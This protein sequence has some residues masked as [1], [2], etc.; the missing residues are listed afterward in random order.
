MKKKKTLK[1]SILYRDICTYYTIQQNKSKLKKLLKSE[2]KEVFDNKY[3]DE[4]FIKYYPSTFNIALKLSEIKTN[5][6]V[7][8]FDVAKYILTSIGGKVST[9]KLQKLCYYVQAWS[10][11]WNNKPLFKEN[12]KRRDNG[13]VCSELFFIHKGFFDV[14]DEI[15]K[16]S[17]LSKSSLSEENMLDID[18]IIV[19]YGKYDVGQLS[20]LSHKEDPWK[21]TKRNKIISNK[22]IKKYY[23][24]L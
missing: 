20:E 13:P 24:N 19:D 23:S 6:E 1:N 22:S 21:N 8:I 18:Q 7:S 2:F 10:L 4:V 17:S 9:M 12:F 5:I 11:V 14:S 16:K 3:I 15:I